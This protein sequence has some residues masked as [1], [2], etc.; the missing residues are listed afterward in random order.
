MTENTKIMFFQADYAIE[1]E[2]PTIRLFGKT[3][4]EKS[5]AL[6][7]DSFTPYFYAIPTDGAD[8]KPLLEKIKKLS[9]VNQEKT[10]KVKNA[11]IVKKTVDGVERKILKIYGN[12]PKDIPYIKDEI[13]TWGLIKDKREFD[14]PYHK[15]YLADREISVGVWYECAFEKK[16]INVAADIKGKLI[17]IKPIDSKKENLKILA[18]DLETVQ[19]KEE[20]IIILVSV[21]TNKGYKKA[22]GYVKD[23]NKDTIIVDSEKA[24]IEKLEQIVQKQDP[25]IIVTYNGDSFDFTVL[26]ARAKKLKC[27]INMGRTKKGTFF[28]KQGI[29]SGAS[30]A[31][32]SHIDLYRFV[33]QIMRATISSETMKLDNVANELLGLKK[34]DMTWEQ[35]EEFW[36]KKKNLGKISE[37]CIH[38]SYITMKLAEHILP[39]I[40][41][42]SA[43]TCQT[44]EDVCRMSYGRLVESYAI[45]RAAKLNIIVP[46]RPTTEMMGERKLLDAIEGAFV[47][48]PKPGLHEKIAL[49]DFRSL[50]PSIIVSHNIDPFTI[51]KGKCKTP[52]P[53]L[54]FCFDTQKKGFVPKVLNELIDE[55]ITLKK[56]LK[57]KTKGTTEF[58]DAYAKQYALKTI[59]NAFY[60]Y[61]G[62]AGSRW[63]KRECAEATTAYGRHYIHKIIDMAKKDGFETI[64]GDTDSIFLKAKNNGEKPEEFAK[65]VNNTLSGIMELEFE[66]SF[67]RGIFVAKKTGIGGAKKRYALLDEKGNITIRGFEKVRRDW[68]PLAKETQEKVL[69]WVLN[70]QKDKAVDFVKK[71]ITDLKDKKIQKEK[72]GIYTQLKRN[73]DKYE[74]VGPHVAAAKRAIARGT[75]I[76]TGQS[77]RYIITNKSGRISDKAEI[78]EFA[79]DYD[80]NYY[81]NNQVLPA[82]MRILS[83]LGV[84]E[85]EILNKGKQ[86]GLFSWSVKK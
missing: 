17:S 65:K 3:D 71:V 27:T 38:D 39:N 19:N 81:I 30:V 29:F 32:R 10:I 34:K 14:I 16:D 25:D 69:S 74:Q 28:K 21:V 48:E 24:L 52:V 2:K 79:K 62:F 60:G 80:T 6:V 13:K 11:I 15:R 56:E 50:Y 83:T 61:L 82:S 40:F 63:Y 9:F 5:I 73:I 31:G 70:N 44:A 54:D 8:F 33:S 1:D 51:H 18:F 37:Y 66:G 43:L 4:T 64:Y 45:K 78:Y 68:S 49:F 77:I 72:L 23:H 59:S 84:T 35:I 41:A 46:N 53:G 75:K 85:D 55:R 7:D 36:K 47:V 58:K 57:S 76:H 67:V 26:E 20:N 22:I 86:K 42:L 12:I